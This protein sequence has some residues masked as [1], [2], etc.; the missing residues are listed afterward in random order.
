MRDRPTQ[1]T[2]KVEEVKGNTAPCYCGGLSPSFLGQMNE[3]LGVSTE[4]ELLF[5]GFSLSAATTRSHLWFEMCGRRKGRARTG[6]PWEVS[7][8]SSPLLPSLD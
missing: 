6:C 1:V 7:S 3:G 4:L 2:F 8:S 5:Q